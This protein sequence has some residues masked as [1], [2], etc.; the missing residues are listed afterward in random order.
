MS[1]TTNCRRCVA[2]AG[3]SHHW[4]P[5]FDDGDWEHSPEPRPVWGCKHCD[6]TMPMDPD[7]TDGE[8][9]EQLYAVHI[10]RGQ[11][12]EE[13][14]GEVGFK[15]L[16]AELQRLE[17]YAHRL[18]RASAKRAEI[19]VLDAFIACTEAMTAL[20]SAV[21]AIEVA[22]TL[23]DG[24]PHTIAFLDLVEIELG[25]APLFAWA[26]TDHPVL[27]TRYVGR[28]D[29]GVRGLVY[30][31]RRGVAVWRW[32]VIDRS[33]WREEGDALS[34]VEAAVAAEIALAGHEMSGARSEQVGGAT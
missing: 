5:G 15:L 25:K 18:E 22:K 29:G 27:R 21:R 17:A 30:Q 26:R 16:P 8:L 9:V 19:S 7:D 13:Q 33:H 12:D 24:P 4:M 10:G 11:A 14:V 20:R 1:E 31:P 34:P 3:A 32:S 28:R 6:F 23:D 2:C